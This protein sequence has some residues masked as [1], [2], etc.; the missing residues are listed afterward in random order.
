MGFFTSLRPLRGPFGGSHLLFMSHFAALSGAARVHAE[1]NYRARGGESAW[2][3][4]SAQAAPC[5]WS[6]RAR[7]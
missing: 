2:L 3:I 6:S 4:A 7:S 1:V 5:I